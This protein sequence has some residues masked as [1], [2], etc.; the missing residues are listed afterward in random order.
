MNFAQQ[1]EFKAA[2]ECG[3]LDEAKRIYSIPAVNVDSDV[4]ATAFKLACK[5]GHLNMCGWLAST[6]DLSAKYGDAFMYACQ[7]GQLKVAKLLLTISPT[8][9]IS[10]DNDNTFRW[11]CANGHLEVAKWLL[12]M[13]PAINIYAES[14]E[15]F[16]YACDNG[17]LEVA[18]WLRSL[19]PEKYQFSTAIIYYEIN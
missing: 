14:D 4:A 9:D 8:I 18:I 13:E 15:A 10:A 5:Y 17:H 1:H 7:Y 3:D 6:F 19:C 12:F 2:C 11:A 16:R